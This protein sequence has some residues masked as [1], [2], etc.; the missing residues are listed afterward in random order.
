MVRRLR[1]VRLWPF[2]D[3]RDFYLW[4]RHYAALAALSPV[5]VCA[6]FYFVAE[7]LCVWAWGEFVVPAAQ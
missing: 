5:M 4:G 1:G 6:F 3:F 2:D 7:E